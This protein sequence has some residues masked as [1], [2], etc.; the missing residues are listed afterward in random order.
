[1]QRLILILVAWAGSALAADQAPAADAFVSKAVS[2]GYG[3]YKWYRHDI[4]ARTAG[5]EL[6]YIGTTDEGPPSGV[7]FLGDA[8]RG[9]SQF[10]KAQSADGRTIV[11]WS[12]CA[13]GVA[14]Q[15][16]MR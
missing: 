2:G 6:D 3:G 5:N 13:G 14:R 8:V 11:F 4:Y 15:L 1:M 12:G 7:G 16:L 9:L 10:T